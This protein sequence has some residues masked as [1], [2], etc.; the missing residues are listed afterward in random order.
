ME[1]TDIEY[2]LHV[3]LDIFIFQ[4]EK[5]RKEGSIFFFFKQFETKAFHVITQDGDPLFLHFIN[6]FSTQLMQLK[7][8]K[9]S[10]A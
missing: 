2:F 5:S 6:T 10:I 7:K 1:F 3:K 9:V 8:K 4:E